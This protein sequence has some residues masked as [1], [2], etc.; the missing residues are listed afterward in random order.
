MP[1]AG[2]FDSAA[3]PTGPISSRPR[4]ILPRPR[5]VALISTRPRPPS[6]AEAPLGGHGI[7]KPCVKLN[8]SASAASGRTASLWRPVT[9]GGTA[10]DRHDSFLD[11]LALFSEVGEDLVQVHK[12]LVLFRQGNLGRQRRLTWPYRHDRG[13]HANITFAIGT[14][15]RA[16]ALSL[17]LCSTYPSWRTSAPSASFGNLHQV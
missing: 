12:R 17:F 8:I 10:L 13:P 3:C 1:G 2:A 9:G 4:V 16:G 14:W 5:G 6:R 7:G 15:V 11:L